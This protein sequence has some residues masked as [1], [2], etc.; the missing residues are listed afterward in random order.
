MTEKT[1]ALTD[2]PYGFAWG[3]VAVERTASDPKW[4]VILTI[5]NDY[6]KQ[7]EVRVSPSGRVLEVLRDDW[8]DGETGRTS[9]RPTRTGATTHRETDDLT[10]ATKRNAREGD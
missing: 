8:N 9:P 3:P 6:G 7:F 2:D 4:G 5:K 1:Y 10:G